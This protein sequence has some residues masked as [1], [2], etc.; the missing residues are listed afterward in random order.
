[1]ACGSGETG[2]GDGPK[3]LEM[4]YDP[5]CFTNDALQEALANGQPRFGNS[6]RNILNI[7]GFIGGE[8]Y[9]D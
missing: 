9:E 6:G 1:V 5:S 7:P 3:T 4:W 8:D 2:Y